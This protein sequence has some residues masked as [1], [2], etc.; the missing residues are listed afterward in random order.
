[1]RIA[2]LDLGS[3]SFHLLVVEARP[4]GHFETLVREKEMLRLGDVV[5][6][7]GRIPD[8]AAEQVIDSIRRL[9]SLAAAADADEFVAFATAA[10]R[11]AENSAAVVD[12]IEARTG[13][14][15]EVISGEEE[16]RLIFAAVQA[17]ISMDRPPALCLDLGGGS[18]EIMVGDQAELLW[19]ASVPLGVARLST[20]LVR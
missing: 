6:R 13:V 12:R 5:S 18:L 11:E 4:D 16:A 10:M 7:E 3:N 17:S 2:A 15:V 8:L 14:A 1:M 9:H 19:S 20:D